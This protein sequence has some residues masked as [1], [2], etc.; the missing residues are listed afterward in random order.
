M[1]PIDLAREVGVSPQMVRNYERLGFLP[2]A[3]RTT[4]GRRAYG[5]DALAA[6]RVARSLMAGYGWQ[7]ALEIMRAVH[8]GDLPAA[9]ALVDSGHAALD[10][11][12][13]QVDEAI[14]ALE[15]AMAREGSGG[16]RAGRGSGPAEAA[17]R[18]GVR[19]SALRFWEQEGLLRPARQRHNNYRVY[20]AE[21]QR[22]LQLVVV[23][24]QLGYRP[25]VI[26][27]VLEELGAGRRER[28]LDALR[29]RRRSLGDASWA[30]MEATVALRGYLEGRGL[31]APP[32]EGA[33]REP[34]LEQAG[35][36]EDL[37]PRIGRRDAPHEDE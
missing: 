3:R 29:E 16:D 2:P 19:T 28:A 21:Q 8:R 5:P 10:A 17:R 25:R 27:S 14:V 31:A 1:R 20:D 34:V 24:R 7:P 35:L 9:L 33:V 30:C 15:R 32:S 36:A 13:R 4:S 18:A 6:L 22:R 26:R 11:R 23:L 37:D 12:R